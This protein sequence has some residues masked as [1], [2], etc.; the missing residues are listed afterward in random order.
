MEFLIK[1]L[2]NDVEPQCSPSL[3]RKDVVQFSRSSRSSLGHRFPGRNGSRSA[4]AS[5]NRPVIVALRRTPLNLGLDESQIAH[6]RT[7]WRDFL[8]MPVRRDQQR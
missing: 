2:G 4:Y 6:A 5:S 7:F 8:Q 1:E 3:T